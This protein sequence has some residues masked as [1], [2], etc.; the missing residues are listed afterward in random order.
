MYGYGK[1][2]VVVERVVVSDVMDAM[3]VVVGDMDVGVV[4]VAGD[5]W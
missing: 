2:C 5:K 1:S 4:V 3:V